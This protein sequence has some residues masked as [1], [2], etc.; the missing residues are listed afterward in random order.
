MSDK[1]LV[2]KYL[3]MVWWMNTNKSY[4]QETFYRFRE[5]TDVVHQ[6]LN[7]MFDCHNSSINGYDV[8]LRLDAGVNIFNV[9][10]TKHDVTFLENIIEA[11]TMCEKRSDR[12]TTTLRRPIGLSVTMSVKEPLEVDDR[13][14]III[15]KDITKAEEL[16]QFRKRNKK[17]SSMPILSWPPYS[18]I[19]DLNEL[20]KIS[21]GIVLDRSF[22]DGSC[23]I[24][25]VL[26][27]AKEAYKPVFHLQPNMI[28]DY[29]EDESNS[30]FRRVLS[31]AQ[32]V[33]TY[34]FDGFIV[35]DSIKNPP[36]P[37]IQT[38][39]EAT[40]IAL[41]DIRPDK[42][43]FRGSFQAKLPSLPPM[44]VAYGASLAALTSG[45]KGILV[46]TTTGVTARILSR[47]SPPC[48]IIAVT[49]HLSAA[50]S[51]HLYKRVT[52]LYYDK[53][54]V[55]SWHEELW[56]RV[57]FGIQFGLDTGLLCFEAKL[58]VLAPMDEGLGYCNSFQIVNVADITKLKWGSTSRTVC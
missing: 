20:I 51:M 27:G 1:S 38:L 7:V 16:L 45:S 56:S 54:R 36:A 55:E 17:L 28:Q 3:T 2:S 58:V 11:I 33:V 53:R 8:Y 15:L 32:N 52:P 43:Y 57:H 49:A 14:D 10:L 9:D 21:T 44:S 26:K 46:L 47:T 5:V 48:P 18:G 24:V 37:F 13:V 29:V 31:Y 25:H 42:E 23:D 30:K 19:E 50:R 41:Q 12:C 34:G 35:V 4:R 22:D 40:Q 6:T 39:V